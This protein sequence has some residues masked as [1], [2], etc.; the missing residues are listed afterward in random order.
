MTLTGSLSPL[1]SSSAP[2]KRIAIFAATPWETAAIRSAFPPGR[3]RTVGG[4]SVLVYTVGEREYWLVQTGIGLEKARQCAA[5]LL[6]VQSFSL[7][8]S[9]GFACALVAADIGVLLVGCEVA[10][11]GG[12]GTEPSAPI[13][14]PGEER[15][16]L[17]AFVGAMVSPERMGRFASTDHVVG[18]A[19]A[20]RAFA[21]KTK[22]IGLDMESAA[23][24]AEA[25]RAHVPFV[26]V[27]TVSDLLHE[28]LPLDF[29]LFLRP[30]GWLKG[31]GHVL[32]APSCLLG[33]GRLRRQSLIAAE[34]LTAF[35]RR[36]A[37]AMASLR[38]ENTLSS[39]SS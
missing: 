29:N 12:E 18:S 25:H 16:R 28:D 13:E 31:V 9:T 35:F 4:F 27:R 10:Y 11:S 7:M 5:R 24:A 36:Y 6:D 21:E 30:T 20:K 34:G 37:L 14:V 8:I 38:Q 22:A 15:D 17:M 23:L 26:I 2:Q 3:E 33:L 39:M 1:A 32:A 19:R